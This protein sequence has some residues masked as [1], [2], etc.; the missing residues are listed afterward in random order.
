LNA[1]AAISLAPQ[2]A[3]IMARELNQND[4]WIANQIAAFV[5]LARN[6]LVTSATSSSHPDR[7]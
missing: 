4:A 3:E 6:Y 1:N 5:A 2:V 7:D